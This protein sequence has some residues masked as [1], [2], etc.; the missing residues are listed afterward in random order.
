MP[1]PITV[2]SYVDTPAPSAAMPAGFPGA[3][4]SSLPHLPGGFSRDPELFEKILFFERI[5]AGPESGMSISHELTFPRETLD[6]RPLPDRL[7]AL[8]VV[9]NLPIQHEKAAVDPP[10]RQLRLFIKR[11]DLIAVEGEPSEARRRT[12]GGDS[13]ELA[14]PLV[15]FSRA[16]NSIFGNPS[17]VVD[18]KVLLFSSHDSKRLK[19]PPVLVCRPVSH[20]LI[21]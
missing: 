19:R 12:D 17:P 21:L 6:R 4:R 9:E 18:Q 7:I 20:V 2:K 10:F 14:F 5:H 1:P 15:G 11:G 8:D 3:P 16:G 13:R